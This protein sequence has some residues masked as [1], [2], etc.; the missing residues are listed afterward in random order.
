MAG[1]ATLGVF[2]G[3]ASAVTGEVCAAAGA[4]LKIKQQPVRAGRGAHLAGDGGGGSDEH[5]NRR[6]AGH[7]PPPEAAVVERVLAVP[8]R[9]LA[10]S[11]LVHHSGL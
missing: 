7:D 11:C 3:T 10:W 4:V 8:R 2:V 5:A 1:E 9:S 6:L